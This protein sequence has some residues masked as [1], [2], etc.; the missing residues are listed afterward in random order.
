MQ[1][2]FRKQ[3]A[4]AADVQADMADPPGY[5]A[6]RT[7]LR[8]LVEKGHLTCTN[9]A[10]RYIYAPTRPRDEAGRSAL[11]GVVQTFYNGSLESAVAALLADRQTGLEPHELEALEQLI[12]QARQAGR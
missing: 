9:Q 1:I 8:I 5:S 11:Q 6:V 2:L 4:S 3:S 7:H 10:G 12:Q